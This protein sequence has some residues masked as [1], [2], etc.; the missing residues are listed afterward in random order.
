MSNPRFGALSTKVLPVV[1]LMSNQMVNFSLFMWCCLSG[2]PKSS[3]GQLQLVGVLKGRWLWRL[4]DIHN[5]KLIF[6]DHFT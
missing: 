2:S 4:L 5:F 6:S 3:L 1:K